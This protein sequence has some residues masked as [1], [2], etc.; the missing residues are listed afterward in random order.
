IELT[1]TFAMSPAA[2]VSGL[3]LHHPSARYFSIGRIARDQVEDYAA[4][5]GQ[6]LRETERWLS[7]NLS[8]D[9]T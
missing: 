4:R 6:E 2:S 8:Y 1:E 9:P 3:Y 7:P 5:K